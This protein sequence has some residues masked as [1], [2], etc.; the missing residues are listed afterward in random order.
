MNDHRTLF[1]GPTVPPGDQPPYFT[2]APVNQIVARGTSKSYTLPAYAD[3]EGDS[4]HL[5]YSTPSWIT[6]SGFTYTFSPP[7]SQ[8]LGA[9]TMSFE[10][11]E[12]VSW[13]SSI[14]YSFTV[15]VTSSN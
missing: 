8:G 7:L 9:Y 10:L 13:L 6:V 14:T 15:T 3:P 5:M 11:M 1:A 4:C 12:D 2:S